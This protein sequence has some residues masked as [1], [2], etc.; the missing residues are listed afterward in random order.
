MDDYI[1]RKEALAALGEEPYVWDEDSDSE[2]Q[3][4]RDWE[5]HYSAISAIPAADVVEVRHAYKI[6]IATVE[7]YVPW[8]KCSACGYDGLFLEDEYCSHCGARLDV[9]A[10]D[11]GEMNGGQDDG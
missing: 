11:V 4:Y 6:N 5:C 3:E 8:C 7:D 10:T 1:P 9:P 2:V